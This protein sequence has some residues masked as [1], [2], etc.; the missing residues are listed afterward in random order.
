MFLV[1]GL[2]HSIWNDGCC[3]LHI[4]HVRVESYVNL[5]DGIVLDFEVFVAC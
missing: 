5:T 3:S 1:A 2:G 4:C